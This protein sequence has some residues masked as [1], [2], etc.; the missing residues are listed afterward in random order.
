MAKKPKNESLL[1]DTT[2]RLLEGPNVASRLLRHPYFIEQRKRRW[3]NVTT[4]LDMK[5]V[6]KTK[7][8]MDKA[9]RRRRFDRACRAVWARRDVLFAC[10][11]RSAVLDL[12]KKHRIWD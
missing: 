2:R 3:R 11:V 9:S 6:P 1:A 5:T 7:P 4:W 10:G 8:K 12:R